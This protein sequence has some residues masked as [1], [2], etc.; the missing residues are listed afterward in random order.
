MNSRETEPIQTLR[1][2]DRDKAKLV[3]A[4]EEASKVA[5]EESQR[6]L[7]VGCS[8]NEAILVLIGENNER[9]M[10][11]VLTRDLSRWGASVLHGR[12]VY[13]G[14][15]C[16]LQIKKLDDT[17]HTRKGEV[18]HIRHVQGMI[19]NLGIQFE[20]PIDLGEFVNLSPEEENKHLQELA[21]DMPEGESTL[22]KSLTQRV[23]IVDDFASDR[24]LLCHWLNKGGMQVASAHDIRSACEQMG[25]EEFDLVVVD[26][27]LGNEQGASL[28]EK[29]RISQFVAPILGVSADDT[30]E[31]EQDMLAAGANAFLAKPFKSEQLVEMAYRLIGMNNHADSEPIFS[32]YNDD[33]DMRP[34]L[35]AFTRGLAK[36]IDE[37]QSANSK[38][39]YD[40]LMDIARTL[41]GAGSGYGL[42]DITNQ[43]GLVLAAMNEED[44]DMNKIKETV[45]DLITTINRVKLH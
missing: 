15:L 39:D 45:N 17:W 3:W 10:L 29:L 31:A 37:L 28:V 41:K 7:R 26:A 8:K 22:V 27:R 14:T 42:D 4:I 24:K 43:A 13:P 44:A 9:T 19:H 38:N 5:V 23:L 11:S 16:E 33:Q 2:S 6:R 12:Y 32:T 36:H 18:R 40:T 21:D 1:L 34:L 25:A 30:G 20:E 35:T